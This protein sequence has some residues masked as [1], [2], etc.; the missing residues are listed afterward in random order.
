MVSEEEE[1]GGD[2]TVVV[3]VAICHLSCPCHNTGT[4]TRLLRTCIRPTRGTYYGGRIG[5]RS[6]G[7]RLSDSILKRSMGS[8]C[9]CA[10]RGR[11]PQQPRASHTAARAIDLFDAV[12]IFLGGGT[13]IIRS[14]SRHSY[15]RQFVL[16]RRS[17]SP[18]TA[19]YY[20][21][22]LLPATNASYCQLLATASYLFSATTSHYCQLLPVTKR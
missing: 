3:V 15:I 10:T 13:P 8:V 7:G 12:A 21:Q 5:A 11:D 6:L 20:C 16:F 22:L 17:G 1:E 14:R 2:A 9:W 19:S 18:A 4:K